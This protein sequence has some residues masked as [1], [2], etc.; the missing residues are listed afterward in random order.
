MISG[1]IIGFVA[2]AVVSYLVLRNNKDIKEK[3]D[4]VTDKID[5]TI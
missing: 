1:L 3:V 4:D 2:G 5:E